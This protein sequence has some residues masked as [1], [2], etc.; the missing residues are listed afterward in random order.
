MNSKIS[1]KDICEKIKE[2]G[3]D[4]IN[5]IFYNENIHINEIM[6]LYE[7]IENN[8]F[9]SIENEFSKDKRLYDDNLKNEKKKKIN[10]YFKKNENLLL[11]KDKISAK[12]KIYIIRYCYNDYEKEDEILKNFDIK[13]LFEHEDIWDKDA[14]NDPKFEEEKKNLI[15]FNDDNVDNLEQYFLALIFQK[16]NDDEESQEDNDVDNRSQNSDDSQKDNESEEHEEEN[17]DDD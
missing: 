3:N 9:S 4:K 10:K 7:D 15:K 14:F 1:L 13:K 17:D 8:L 2:N 12:A 6:D 16:E 11:T 5:G